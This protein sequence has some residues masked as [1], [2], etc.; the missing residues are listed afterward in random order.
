MPPPFPTWRLRPGC[1]PMLRCPGSPSETP[2]CW[3]AA[4]AAPTSPG[5]HYRMGPARE[6]NRQH[7]A[8]WG[9]E[10]RALIADPI[11]V[12]A[13]DAIG[14]SME[15]PTGQAEARPAL[16]QAIQLNPREAHYYWA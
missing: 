13:H 12:A 6:A 3:Q 7:G 11:G 14:Q 8:A 15:H 2:A 4:A 16:E 5:V 9:Q 10:R 1:S